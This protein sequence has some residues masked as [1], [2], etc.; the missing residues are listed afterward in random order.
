MIIVMAFMLV[1]DDT[2]LNLATQ[3]TRIVVQLIGEDSF[4]GNQSISTELVQRDHAKSVRYFGQFAIITMII[5]TSGR[6]L[7][8]IS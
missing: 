2:I 5:A 6:S 7:T 8:L 1:G 4:Y 3:G